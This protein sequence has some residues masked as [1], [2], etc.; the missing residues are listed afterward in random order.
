MTTLEQAL[1]SF[2]AA[3]LAKFQKR[4]DKHGARSVT[5]AGDKHLHEDGVYE[6]LWHHFDDEVQEMRRAEHTEDEMG[7]AV[8]VANMAFLIWWRDRGT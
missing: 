1:D 7:E 4:A 8:D 6:G 2:R 3:M 5:V